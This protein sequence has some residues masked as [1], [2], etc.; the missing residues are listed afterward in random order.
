[1]TEY[2][3]WNI[4]L[5]VVV[6]GYVLMA[7]KEKPNFNNY[8]LAILFMSVMHGFCIYFQL[9][10]PVS[11]LY[12]PF[13][14][15]A[16]NSHQKTQITSLK[17]SLHFIPFLLFTISYLLVLQVYDVR[18]S[19]EG[20]ALLY[21]LT[22]FVITFLSLTVYPIIVY[23]QQK[24]PGGSLS[25]RVS[26]LIMQLNVVCIL[27]AAF[28]LF[29]S[30][31]IYK[32]MVL[33]FD[34]RLLV[35][36]LLVASSALIVFYLIRSYIAAKASFQQK[37]RIVNDVMVNSVSD[38]A[39][40]DSFRYQ[41]CVLGEDVLKEY[42]HKVMSVLDNTNIY[43]NPG[44]SLDVLSRETGIYKHHFS[45]LFNVYLRK[46]F[47]QLIAEYRIRYALECINK[48]DNITIEALAYE[49]G[50]SSKT[51]FN[52]YFK[53]ITGYSPSEYRLLLKPKIYKVATC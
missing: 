10:I 41:K 38:M 36:A 23:V 8:L 20:Y 2:I 5:S 29:L 52:K 13:L 24:R 4:V 21:Y 27:N 1:M 19:I 39:A 16:S 37:K 11:L 43:L 32:S 35:Y 31:V 6:I 7:I 40:A 17:K 30:M 26:M 49:C 47:Y 45:Q 51:S 48:E 22:Y 42:A 14:F 25:S 9:G 44:I 15:L 50:F 46:N 34:I 12:G 33:G 53:E 3:L 18:V 28:I